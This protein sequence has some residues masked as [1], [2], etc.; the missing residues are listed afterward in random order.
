[1]PMTN[2]RRLH[3]KTRSDYFRGCRCTACRKAESHYQRARRQRLKAERA[4]ATATTEE[5]S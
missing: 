3:G 4:A 2:K 1:M 5:T